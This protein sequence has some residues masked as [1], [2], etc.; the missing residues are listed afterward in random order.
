MAPEVVLELAQI[1]AWF[2][3]LI[4]I[5]REG[6]GFW[7]Y[8]E[9]CPGPFSLAAGACPVHPRGLRGWRVGDGT[10]I[11]EGIHSELWIRAFSA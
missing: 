5:C 4:S 7:I 9:F 1:F 11:L 2:W 6:V 8:S 3:C 10:H